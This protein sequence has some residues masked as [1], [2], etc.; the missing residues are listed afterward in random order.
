MLSEI[1][2]KVFRKISTFFIWNF[3]SRRIFFI[4]TFSL[5]IYDLYN[6]GTKFRE[7]P[8]NIWNF[9]Y[10]DYRS[11]LWASVSAKTCWSATGQNPFLSPR[12]FAVRV[13]GQVRQ[14]TVH[15]P[16]DVS[17]VQPDTEHS[18]YRTVL[19]ENQNM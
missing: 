1:P 12:R 14:K 6:I 10:F 7:I 3:D 9:F 4:F 17:C 16:P 5:Q 19:Q 18:V 13:R 8:T 2:N 11:S 15:M